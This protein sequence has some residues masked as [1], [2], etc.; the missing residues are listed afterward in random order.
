MPGAPAL[1][2][3]CVCRN[4][5]GPMPAAFTA[6]E[7]ERRRVAIC[8]AMERHG[9]DALL[10]GEPANI[11]WAT[12]YDAW[13]FYTPQYLLVDQNGALFWLGRL[14]D[15]GA[16]RFTTHLPPDQVIAYPEDLVQQDGVHPGD[17][18]GA[19]MKDHGLG[20]A[21]IGYEPDAY[22]MSPRSLAAVQAQLPDATWKN[23]DLLV[24]WCRLVKS[25]AEI[26]VMKRAARLAEYA[27][28]TALS[29]LRAGRRQS[30][31][32]ADVVAAGIR[33][34]D[35]FGGDLTAVPPLLLAGEK[36]STAHPMWD[37]S[38][39][40]AGQTVAFELGGC[41]KRYNVGLA[42]TGHIGKLPE[43]RARVSEAVQD[44]MRAVISAAKPG[45]TGGEVHAAWQA[46]LDRYGLE[47]PSRIGYS[48]GCGYS[49]DWGEHSF[50]V[51]PSEKTELQPNVVIHVIL[52][53]WMDD[54]GLEL[55]ETLHITEQGAVCLCDF[56]WDVREVGA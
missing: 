35:G 10:I 40:E 46:V 2:Q 30:D 45:A 1:W 54:W 20:K 12:G 49:P 42:R 28:E 3:S 25:D 14:M 48:I 56:P 53:M 33:G 37:D 43:D 21:R 41:H 38:L 11:T 16:A 34:P 52:G 6:Q 9:L 31:L 26:A 23:A 18:V 29:G 4:W 17:W 8:A 47:K 5:G 15:A 39:F 22:M 24:N 50:S 13:S 44:G 27:N 7:Y 36:A 55:S 19:W 51:R 32:M